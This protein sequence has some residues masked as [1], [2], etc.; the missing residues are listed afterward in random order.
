MPLST[1]LYLP[2]PGLLCA[3]VSLPLSK[4]S[5]FCS[6]LYLCPKRAVYAVCSTFVQREQFLQSVLPLSKESSLCSVFYLFSKRAVSEVCS[7]FVQIE[8]FMQSTFEHCQQQKRQP[9][10]LNIP[11]RHW[12]KRCYEKN[13]HKGKLQ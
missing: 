6:L 10:K 3:F 7:T 5:S 2:L 12:K 11:T 1:F 8:Q 13:K 4:E 9:R